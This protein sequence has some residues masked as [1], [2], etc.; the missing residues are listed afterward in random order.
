[1]CGEQDI[2]LDSLTDSQLLVAV[3]TPTPVD[4]VVPARSVETENTLQPAPGFNWVLEVKDR[5]SG[6]LEHSSEV[7]EE[8]QVGPS[9]PPSP[10]E[11]LRQEGSREEVEQR[12]HQSEP[13]DNIQKAQQL[14]S[15][16][17]AQRQ[18]S[19]ILL[20]NM[21]QMAE[22][23]FALD[24]TLST[25]HPGAFLPREEMDLCHLVPEPVVYGDLDP[26][27]T[28]LLFPDSGLE[29]PDLAF[30]LSGLCP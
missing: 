9:L 4:P 30:P 24:Q 7:Q 17:N 25:A 12:S 21:D 8:G 2:F 15:S 1:M 18:V 29:K 13:S 10:V 22:H 14:I 23:K 27:Y 20:S 5:D 28:G 3:K 26:N 11:S 16:I 6:H 19:T